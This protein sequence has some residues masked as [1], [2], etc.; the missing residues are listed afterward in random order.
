LAP[1]LWDKKYAFLK[2]EPGR[3]LKTKDRESK[4]K[5]SEPKNEA[6][7]LLKIRASGK[8]GPKN[9]PGHVIENK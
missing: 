2:N 3:L 4:T 8:N 5:L 6:G 9:K 1:K 7:K